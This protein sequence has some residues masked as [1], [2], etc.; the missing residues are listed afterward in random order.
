M[1]EFQP[2]TKSEAIKLFTSVAAL[3]DALSI[4]RQAVYKWPDDL[5]QEQADRVIGAAIRLGRL[6]PLDAPRAEAA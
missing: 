1:V 6:D 5:P 3:A 2:M 4:S